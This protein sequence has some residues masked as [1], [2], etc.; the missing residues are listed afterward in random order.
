MTNKIC[1]KKFHLTVIVSG[2]SDELADN[3]PFQ[4]LKKKKNTPTV[5]H[6]CCKT[7]FKKKKPAEREIL[8]IEGFIIM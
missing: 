3:T 7:P 6:V 5:E 4:D 1:L 8:R 2:K